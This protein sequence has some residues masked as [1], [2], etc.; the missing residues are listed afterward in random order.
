MFGLT[1]LPEVEIL[2]IEMQRAYRIECVRL[3][4]RVLKMKRQSILNWGVDS[5]EFPK[6]PDCHRQ[7]LGMYYERQELMA[8][9][10]RLRRFTA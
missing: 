4:G 9:L 3:L 1:G 10:K 7:V 5:L 2:K 8:E 6:M